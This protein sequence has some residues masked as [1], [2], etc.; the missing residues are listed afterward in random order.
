[1]MVSSPS[2]RGY[3]SACEAAFFGI[4]RAAYSFCFLSSCITGFLYAAD[5]ASKKAFLKAGFTFPSALAGMF[6]IT[7]SLMVMGENNAAKVSTTSR[8]LTTW[9][10]YQPEPNPHI[11]HDPLPCVLVYN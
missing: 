3:S 4:E 6:F 11:S 8:V 9:P 10:A 5:M 1:M 2:L 7:A